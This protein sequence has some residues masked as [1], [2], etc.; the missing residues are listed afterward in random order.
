MAFG[1]FK[2]G[3]LFMRLCYEL[4]LE[5]MA[6][7]TITDKVKYYIN[8]YSDY[9]QHVLNCNK[10]GELLISSASFCFCLNR[11]WQDFSMMQPPLTSP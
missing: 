1:E 8:Y 10:F 3:P 9:W 7:A 5:E 2:F 11:K 4:G 6:A